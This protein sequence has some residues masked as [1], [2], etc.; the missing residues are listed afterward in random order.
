MCSAQAKSSSL[1]LFLDAFCVKK[2]KTER[3]VKALG[4]NAD[5]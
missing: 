5:I 4:H 3:S 1:W 2:K